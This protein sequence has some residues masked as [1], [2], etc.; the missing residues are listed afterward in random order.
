MASIIYKINNKKETSPIYV[1]FKI[2]Q[3]LEAERKIGDYIIETKYWDSV[4]KRIKIKN[5][6]EYNKINEKL[7]EFEGY[8]SSKFSIDSTN[9]Q[10]HK[11]NLKEWL[12]NISDDFFI[13]I[14]KTVDNP[15]SK[16]Y[17]FDEYVNYFNLNIDKY[18]NEKGE[19]YSKSFKSLFKNIELKLKLFQKQYKR[20]KLDEVNI[21]FRNEFVD[22]LRD[23]IDFEDSTI[24]KY[25][26]GIK[27]I[28]KY[29]EI[30]NLPISNDYLKKEFKKPSYE[31]LDVYLNENEIQKIRNLDLKSI[32]DLD[33]YRDCF[34]IALRVGLRYS[35]L[36]KLNKNEIH[37][38]KEKEEILGKYIIIK[39]DKT[40]ETVNIPL[41]ENVLEILDKY[42]NKFPVPRSNPQ[43]N[44]YIKTI[45]KRAKIDEK[46]EGK[47]RK[48]IKIN[49]GLKDEYT[50][51]RNVKD[52]YEKWELVKAH[53]TRRSFATN[54]YLEGHPV[55]EIM[56][57][58]GHKTEEMFYKYIKMTPK[59]MIGNVF[60]RWNK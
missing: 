23:E 54:M 8:L 42:N 21:E 55:Y 58:T 25:I 29:A 3:Q 37:I 13:P 47:I 44:Q 45:C 20:I 16:I 46:Y 9:I 51:N 60:K 48:A 17:Y 33:Y 24:A 36:E 52:Y 34:I 19:T 27:L 35:D 41:H 10:F 11:A 49:E 43:F 57:I 26:K 38:Y 28:C 39:T 59:E 7:T 14:K 1:R 5:K 22:F 32:P 30:N 50:L 56:Q 12:T 2:N 53:T 15:L 40:K 6:P 4:K 18:K 31:T